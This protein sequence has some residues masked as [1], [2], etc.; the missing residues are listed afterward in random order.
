MA[1]AAG[2]RGRG[3]EDAVDPRRIS[4]SGGE[5]SRTAESR[6]KRGRTS[7]SVAKRYAT[8]THRSAESPASCSHRD[9]HAADRGSL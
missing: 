5:I 6:R 8:W 3:V 4:S 2:E 1:V 9:A 7:A